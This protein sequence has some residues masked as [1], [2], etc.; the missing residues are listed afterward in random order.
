MRCIQKSAITSQLLLFHGTPVENLSTASLRFLRISNWAPLYYK[1]NECTMKKNLSGQLYRHTFAL[2][3]QNIQWSWT[4]FIG[5]K[6][7]VVPRNSTSNQKARPWTFPAVKAVKF[8]GICI[9]KWKIKRKLH[10][11]Q[12]KMNATTQDSWLTCI[13]PS[14]EYANCETAF[15][16]HIYQYLTTAEW[17]IHIAPKL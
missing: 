2:S 17:S 1:P 8:S 6:T 5:W 7:Y 12:W 14:Q 9:L 4:H 3:W 13:P 10:A 11:W 16:R 15:C